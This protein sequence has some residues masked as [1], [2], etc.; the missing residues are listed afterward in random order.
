M[1]SSTYRKEQQASLTDLGITDP[2]RQKILIE[3]ID[4]LADLLVEAYLH[5]SEE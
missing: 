2:E 1:H 3:E 5:G 4:Y